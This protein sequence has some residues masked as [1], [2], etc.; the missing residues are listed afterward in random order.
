MFNEHICYMSGCGGGG[1]QF[2]QRIVWDIASTPQTTL[3]L[4]V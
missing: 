2:D 4:G 3:L 1:S